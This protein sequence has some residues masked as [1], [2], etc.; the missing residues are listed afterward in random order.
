[1]N[2]RIYHTLFS[3]CVSSCNILVSISICGN[4][5]LKFLLVIPFVMFDYD[6][7]F[8]WFGLIIEKITNHRLT[9][10]N[11]RHAS[12][13]L[14]CMM[15]Y[16]CRHIISSAPTLHRFLFLF[17]SPLICSCNNSFR[18]TKDQDRTYRNFVVHYVFIIL[19]SVLYFIYEFYQKKI[20]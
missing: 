13:I 14:K 6:D 9:A 3:E 10:F 8:L 2:L 16:L 15:S 11:C 7:T 20:K 18:Y 5:W 4:E 12:L 19:Y 1:M 17:L